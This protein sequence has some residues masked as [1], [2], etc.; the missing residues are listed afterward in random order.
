MEISPYE[1]LWQLN[2]KYIIWD[3]FLFR[4]KLRRNVHF[5]C[6][7]MCCKYMFYTCQCTDSNFHWN[8][9]L[10]EMNGYKFNWKSIHIHICEFYIVML[11]FDVLSIGRALH[12][13]LDFEY[14]LMHH[15][16][17]HHYT[18]YQFNELKGD[19]FEFI[20]HTKN[21]EEMRFFYTSRPLWTKAF[22]F[23]DGAILF[24]FFP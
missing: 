11:T 13:E 22:G 24:A 2:S 3:A 7:T 15:I 23:S 17:W 16:R 10:F 5:F 18:F 6:F 4:H 19:K 20:W 9:E 14:Q 1:M 21:L 12:F 8:I